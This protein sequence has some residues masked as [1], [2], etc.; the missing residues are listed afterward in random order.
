[1]GEKNNYFRVHPRAKTS[2][3]KNEKWDKKKQEELIRLAQNGNLEARNE[4]I[5]NNLPLITKIASSMRYQYKRMFDINDLIQE[6]VFGIA[7]SIERYKFDFGTAFSTYATFWITQSILKFI[8]NNTMTVFKPIQQQASEKNI[9]HF[10]QKHLTK[11]GELPN[12]EE[13]STSLGKTSKYI[14]K[15]ILYNTREVYF[16]DLALF[17][18]ENSE[19][20]KHIYRD[21]TSFNPENFFVAREELEKCRQ[22]IQKIL[23]QLLFFKPRDQNIFCVYYGLNENLE[24]KVME[25]IG[26]ELGIC[27]ERIRQIIARI[28]GRISKKYP[29]FNSEWLIQEISKAEE[30]SKIIGF[31]DDLAKY[32]LSPDLN[33]HNSQ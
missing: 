11:H 3:I 14:E 9:S 21:N 26:Q 16:D 2:S 8:Y 33:Y 29:L 10:I 1:M 13:I 25:K 20:K 28:W 15:R 19:G 32:L 22:N 31:G 18:E 6:G 12:L 7:K 30:L 23:L 24:P 4:L 5:T 27:R 17:Q